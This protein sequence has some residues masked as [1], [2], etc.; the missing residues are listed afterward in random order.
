MLLTRANSFAVKNCHEGLFLHVIPETGEER[1]CIVVPIKRGEEFE[2]CGKD[3][4]S[5]RVRPCPQGLYQPDDTNSAAEVTCM[6]PPQCIEG[7]NVE[8]E[9]CRDGFCRK[10]CICNVKAGKCGTFY[11]QC[12]DIP[13]KCP[14]NKVHPNCSCVINPQQAHMVG[15]YSNISGSIVMRR[16]RKGLHILNMPTVL[17]EA[18]VAK[19]SKKFTTKFI[20]QKKW[21]L[22]QDIISR[23]RRLPKDN[24]KLKLEQDKERIESEINKVE[25]ELKSTAHSQEKNNNNK[26]RH[27]G[28]LSKSDRLQNGIF[29]L[30]EKK[31]QIELKL[32]KLKRNELYSNYKKRE[33]E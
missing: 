14:E 25:M 29:N 32:V 8:S 1:C 12:E 19:F 2:I 28:K 10:E 6:T 30:Q 16:K 24:M 33:S 13:T 20:T 11:Y 17:L 5:D 26:K 31:L 18:T 27:K 22:S 21:T 4:E 7:E 23:K 3:G 9:V 15:S